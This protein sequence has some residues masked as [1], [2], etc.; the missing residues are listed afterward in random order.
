M[1]ANTQNLDGRA[2][3]MGDNEGKV[4]EKYFHM[5]D[6]GLVFSSQELTP[7]FKAIYPDPVKQTFSSIYV[8]QFESDFTSLENIR[9]NLRPLKEAQNEI[10][11]LKTANDELIEKV[12]ELETSENKLELEKS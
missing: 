5:P 3:G 7:A 11:E 10:D 8:T 12:T 6:T 4:I 9:S 1:D 2:G